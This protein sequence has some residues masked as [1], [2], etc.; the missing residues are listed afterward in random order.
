VTATQ[1][2]RLRELRSRVLLRAFDYRQRRHARGAWFRFRRTLAFA[3]EAYAVPRDEADRL[4]A[5]GYLPEPV[6]RELEPP[7]V[8]LFVAPERAARIAAAEPLE[9]R[10][11]AELLAAECLVLV[12]FPDEGALREP[13][14]RSRRP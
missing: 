8:V 4:V 10:L 1:E 9:M 7:R 14:A 5:E 2:R 11:S 13:A 12:P 6:G 3:S